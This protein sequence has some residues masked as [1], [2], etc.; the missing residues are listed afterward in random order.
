[1]QS[2]VRVMETPHRID[3]RFEAVVT[4][5][6]NRGVQHSITALGVGVCK[7]NLLLTDVQSSLY[8]RSYLP[9]LLFFPCF[10]RF[11][12]RPLSVGYLSRESPVIL[13][14]PNSFM[15]N[16]RSDQYVCLILTSC[17][18]LYETH[19]IHTIHT[20]YTIFNTFVTSTWQ[21]VT[22]LRSW[23]LRKLRGKFRLKA[24]R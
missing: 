5:L 10:S 13:H 21:P 2:C 15:N 1:M 9:T 22:Q 23:S 17:Q 12:D 16:R 24:S 11:L 19:P 14:G 20:P 8:I 18:I 3:S 4:K 6:T 7:V